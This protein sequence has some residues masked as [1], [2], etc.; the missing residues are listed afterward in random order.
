MQS[1]QNDFVI[2][3]LQMFPVFFEEGIS[4]NPVKISLEGIV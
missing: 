4:L 3:L 1:M 2:S